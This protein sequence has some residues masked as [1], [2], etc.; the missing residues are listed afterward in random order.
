[1]HPQRPDKRETKP[2]DVIHKPKSRF[3]L[4]ILRT[5]LPNAN[6]ASTLFMNLINDPSQTCDM[7]CVGGM[8]ETPENKAVYCKQHLARVQ[9]DL[10][11]QTLLRCP[12]IKQS[13]HKELV[14]ELNIHLGLTR[15]YMFSSQWDGRFSFDETSVSIEE[16]SSIKIETT[17]NQIPLSSFTP[18]SFPD[19]SI[20]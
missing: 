6:L 10:D 9:E 7:E 5:N 19:R 1:M 17:C 12:C 16:I 18:L 15:T 4:Q 14:K 2:E 8:K 11:K 13:K 20:Q 3:T